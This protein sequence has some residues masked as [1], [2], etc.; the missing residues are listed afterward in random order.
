[1]TF[2]NVR[3]FFGCLGLGLLSP[4]VG[5]GSELHI[6]VGD[7]EWKV[8]DTLCRRDPISKK[9]QSPATQEAGED[10]HVSFLDLSSRM[11][12]VLVENI[13]QEGD[14]KLPSI[15]SWPS[16]VRFPYQGLAEFL[17]RVGTAGVDSTEEIPQPDL[18]ETPST[19]VHAWIYIQ[20]FKNRFPRYQISE[21]N[22]YRLTLGAVLVAQKYIQDY[23]YWNIDMSTAMG[24]RRRDLDSLEIEFLRA[25]EWKLCVSRQEYLNAVQ[26]LLNHEVQGIWQ[27]Q[28]LSVPEGGFQKGMWKI[29]DARLVFYTDTYSDSTCSGNYRRKTQDFG[30]LVVQRAFMNGHSIQYMRLAP[31][32]L[33]QVFARV[34]SDIYV[35]GFERTLEDAQDAFRR[36]TLRF[37]FVGPQTRD[38]P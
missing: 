34:G 36:S 1:M 3:L 6:K 27:T 14:R 37:Q 10:L 4:A 33:F 30:G 22:L 16:Y 31:F 21:E 28:C 25:I 8:A 35:G 24:L 32:H 23:I 29:Q 9:C 38:R 5:F 12:E 13:Q 20:R 19:L 26:F 7:Q 15:W 18:S 11:A 2:K 17:N